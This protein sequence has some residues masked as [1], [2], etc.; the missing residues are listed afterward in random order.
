[1]KSI[2]DKKAQEEMVGFVLIVVLVAIIAVIF[3]GITL[4]K[5]SNKIGQES[6]RLSSFLSA[7]S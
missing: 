4:R 6:E 3:L 7:V 1:M 5:P 2:K